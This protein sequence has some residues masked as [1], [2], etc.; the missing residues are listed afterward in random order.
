MS[1]DR[2]DR[3]GQGQKVQAVKLGQENGRKHEMEL[4]HGRAHGH[5]HA[6]DAEKGRQQI[7]QMSY[8]NEQQSVDRNE[9]PLP[10]VSVSTN[11]ISA[12][13]IPS[14]LIAPWEHADEEEHSFIEV[15]LQLLGYLIILCNFLKCRL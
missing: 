13:A 4:K 10:S 15:S 8:Q 5:E 3:Y 7:Q 14:Q 2:D 11:S 1:E 9:L 6:A 12:F